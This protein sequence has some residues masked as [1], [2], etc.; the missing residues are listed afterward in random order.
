MNKIRVFANSF[1]SGLPDKFQFKKDQGRDA[2]EFVKNYNK[3]AHFGGKGDLGNKITSNNDKPDE[4][5]PATVKQSI[6]K[7]AAASKTA[8]DNIPYSELQSGV[9]QSAIGRELPGMVKAQIGRFN[10]SKQA[11]QDFIDVVVAK[12]FIEKETTKWGTNPKGEEMLNKGT[13]YGFLNGR[14]ALRIKDVVREE[15][16]RNPEERIYL[17]GID[18]NQ[19]ET[20]DKAANVVD[21][22]PVD[23]KE[24]APKYKSLSESGVVSK[25]AIIDIKKKVLSTVRTLK[26]AINASVSINKT[27]T[28]LIAEIKKELGKQVD[29]NLKEEMGGKKDAVL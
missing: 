18:T 25:D 28:P 7:S 24:E 8:L 13:L 19:F 23:K 10:L 20:L 29:I 11:R 1:L 2:Y 27:V 15:Y 21:E 16:K 17:A 6:T 5:I 22:A 26:S 3:A 14:I 12:M 4:E 9:S